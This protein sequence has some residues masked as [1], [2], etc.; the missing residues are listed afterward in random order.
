MSFHWDSTR[1][2]GIGKISIRVKI[3]IRAVKERLREGK[4]KKDKGQGGLKARLKT[5][6]AKD[7]R[8]NRFVLIY[9]VF[10]NFATHSNRRVVL[11]ARVRIRAFET[12]LRSSEKNLI[13]MFR[14]TGWM[15]D[16]MGH[17]YKF[18]LHRQFESRSCSEFHEN[19]R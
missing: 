15:W 16:D 18:L 4:K 11:L 3:S 2:T 10:R 12:E 8:R 9:R 19:R 5:N 6:L 17:R 14:S 1:S 7:L 13:C